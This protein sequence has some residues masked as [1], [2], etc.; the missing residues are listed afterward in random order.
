MGQ[1]EYVCV[2]TTTERKKTDEKK[3]LKSQN[4]HYIILIYDSFSHQLMTF[5]PLSRHI[6]TISYCI[7]IIIRIQ[8]SKG[9]MYGFFENILKLFFFRILT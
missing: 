5:I 9:Y 1:K 2:L 8:M 4:C 3:F 6:E 7:R